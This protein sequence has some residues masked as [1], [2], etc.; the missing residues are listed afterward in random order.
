MQVSFKTWQTEAFDAVQCGV[1]WWYHSEFSSLLH[2]TQSC[3]VVVLMV[4][5]TAGSQP[6]PLGIGVRLDRRLELSWG[7]WIQLGRACLQ[8]VARSSYFILSSWIFFYLANK[9][10]SLKTVWWSSV[11]DLFVNAGHSIQW[12]G[13]ISN[14]IQSFFVKDKYFG[15]RK[16]FEQQNVSSLHKSFELFYF[17]I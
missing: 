16:L 11:Y 14:G 10:Q 7:D 8:F 6:L 9:R 3:Y 4:Y 15:W 1:T 13:T 5:G 12:K 2:L 17:P